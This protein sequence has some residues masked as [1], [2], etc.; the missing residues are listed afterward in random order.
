MSRYEIH[1]YSDT[2][3]HKHIIT[4]FH[5]LEYVRVENDYGA[6]ILTLPLGSWKWEDFH[7]DDILEIWRDKGGSIQLQNQTAYF[8]RDWRFY[9]DSRGKDFAEILA[10]DA[11]YLLDGAIV[12]FA[13]ESAQA[14]KT[15]YADDMIKEVVTE[16][17]VSRGLGKITVASDLSAAASFTKHF[18]WRNVLTV[19]KEIAEQANQNGDYLVFDVVRT[20]PCT[21]QL[22][23]FTGQRGQ[24]HSRGS[25]DPKIVSRATGNLLEASFSESHSRER[26]YII[27]GGQG[28]ASA[29]TIV[30]RSDA[31]RMASS[32]WNRRELFADGRNA[33]TTAALNSIGDAKLDE[34]RPKQV[35]T[36]KITDTEGMKFNIHYGF[37]DLL[38]AE[39]FGYAVDCHVSSVKVIA[40]QNGE[41]IDIRLRGEL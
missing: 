41:R 10:Y 16:N 1:W 13:A 5:K 20:N 11:N 2:G 30:Y 39:A 32:A 9:T 31:G 14:A 35:M 18:A 4:G 28:E 38:T 36:G 25:N 7:E 33:T 34:Y 17:L 40:D 19:C 37:G 29:R 3:N 8:V 21:F 6:S 22:Q 12:N 23:T 24:D 26:N 15:D 27:V